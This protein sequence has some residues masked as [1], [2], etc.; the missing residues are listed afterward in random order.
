M[1]QTTEQRKESARKGWETRRANKLAA[2]ERQQEEETETT[3]STW[4]WKKWLPWLLLALFVIGMLT[5][6]PWTTTPTAP[7]ITE[8]PVVQPTE[9]PVIPTEAPVV[10][11]TAAPTEAPVVQPTE[12]PVASESMAQVEVPT[13]PVIASDPAP[14]CPLWDPSANVTQML[15]PGMTAIGD[16]VVN[17]TVQYDNGSG[18]STIV[19]NLSSKNVDIFAEWGS[20]C[21]WTTDVESVAQKQRFAGCNDSDGDGIVDG[22][23]KVRVVLI[24]D[25]GT[26]VTFRDPT[27]K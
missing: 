26:Q 23:N 2:D 22:C 18:E 3:D 16:V 8:A 19:V 9:A 20:G 7:A 14:T 15:P 11:P 4:N 21:E 24:T 27:I 5:W 17:G 6:H 1:A 25:L 10:E 12:V 13:G